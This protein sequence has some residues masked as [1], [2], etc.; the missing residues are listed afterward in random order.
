[1]RR[2]ARRFEH[3]DH[4]L[5]S[6]PFKCVKKFIEAHAVFE[7]AKERIHRHPGAAEARLSTEPIRIAPDIFFGKFEG[8]RLHA[9]ELVTPAGARGQA[10]NCSRG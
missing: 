5:T 1:M 6:H 3:T 4:L 2:C 9:G 8:R 10:A 7:I